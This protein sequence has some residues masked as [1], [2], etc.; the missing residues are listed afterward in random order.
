MF[1]SRT[2]EAFFI[3]Q[4]VVGLIYALILRS[5]SWRVLGRSA[6]TRFDLQELRRIWGYSMGMGGIAL[7]ALVFTQLDKVLLSKLIGLG[8]F[9][10]YVLASTV[11]SGLYVLVSPLFNALYPRFTQLV[12]LGEIGTL[13]ALYR[14]GTRTL[15]SVLFPVAVVLAALSHEVLYLWTGNEQLATA[16]APLVALL[17]AG[18]ALHGIMY[19][20]YALQLAYGLPQ[21]TLRINLILLAVQV[22]LVLSLGYTLGVLGGAISW[23]VLHVLNLLL[24]T[25]ITHRRVLPGIGGTWL[26]RDVGVPLAYSLLLGIVLRFVVVPLDWTDPIKLLTGVVLAIMLIAFCFA[27]SPEMY[28]VLSKNFHAHA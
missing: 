23:L 4:A 27:T 8:D 20:P 21:V 15:S 5:L 6:D 13:T 25:W 11:V 10:R 26:A 9:G 22:P 3:W 24:G 28:A 1:V 16:A 2:I 7:S 17:G 19:F 14:L 12:T 18:S